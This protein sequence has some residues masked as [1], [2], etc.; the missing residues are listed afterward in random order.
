MHPISRRVFLAGGVAVVLAS[1]SSSDESTPDPTGTSPS[2]PPDTSPSDPP[3]TTSSTTPDTTSSTTPA[4]ST[5]VPAP[6]VDLPADPFTLGVASGDA[7]ATAVILW[8]RLAPDPLDG[9]GMPADTVDIAYDVARDEEFTDVVLSEITSAPAQYGHSV[10]VAAE[11]GPGWHY[12]RFR[13]GEY[14]SPVGRTRRAPGP[15]EATEP[16]RFASASCQN[17]EAGYYTA[18]SDIAAQQ[19]DFVAFLGDYIYEGAGGEIGVGDAVRTHGS[20]EPTDLVGYRNRY[21][22]YKSDPDLQAAHAACPWYVT[23]DDHEVENNYA[24]LIPQV[25]ADT[26]TFE[27]RRQQAYQVW[28]EH[29]PVA[30]DPPDATGE[31]RIY[32]SFQWGSL[33]GITLLDGRQYRSD[34]ACGDVTLSTEP[35]CPETFD[36]TRSMLGDEQEQWLIDTLTA[37]TSTWSMIAQ[38]TVFGDVTLGDAVL[39]YDQW[40]GYPASRN[41]IVDTL[42][43]GRNTVVLT[44]DIHFAGIG[45]MRQGGRGTGTPVAVEFVATSI[46]SGGI[47][48]DSLTDIVTSIPDIVDVELVHR[49]YTL[50]TVDESSWS[51]DFRIVETVKEPGAPVTSY[52]TFRVEAGTNTVVKV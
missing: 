21:G 22:L 8:T 38:Q 52:A 37:D 2:D 35:P 9:G 39:N 19:P 4:A 31:F 14:T 44:G 50:H 51:A 7:S 13:V 48:D 33:L 18:H 47:V 28:W 11:I 42:D 15:D 27:E 16:V 45:M 24:G 26:P 36:E 10:H 6:D 29:Q 30:L 17:Y 32:R 3:D 20:A 1:C 34:Q 12:Y 23:W 5:V 40:D 49:G 41:R 25:V 46:S 43:P